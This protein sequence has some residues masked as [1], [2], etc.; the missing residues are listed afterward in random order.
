MGELVPAWS[1]GNVVT[2][3]PAEGWKEGLIPAG[4][5]GLI[6]AAPYLG[7]NTDPIELNDHPE[8]LCTELTAKGWKCRGRKIQDTDYCFSHLR[9]HNRGNEPTADQGLRT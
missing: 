5:D 3:V 6:Q 7:D 9:K 4:Q 8:H 2:Q 1:Y